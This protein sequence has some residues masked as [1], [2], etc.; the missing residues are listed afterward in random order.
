MNNILLA[1]EDEIN[2]YKNGFM[3]YEMCIEGIKELINDN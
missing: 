1:I 2:Q 3:T